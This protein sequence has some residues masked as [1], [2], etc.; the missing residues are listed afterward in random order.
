MVPAFSQNCTI[1][2]TP[3]KLFA[4]ASP[5]KITA[6]VTASAPNCPWFVGTQGTWVAAFPPGGQGN[7]T[8]TLQ[9]APNDT[10]GERT[11]SLKIGNQTI[12][13]TQKISAQLFDDVPPSSPFFDSIALMKTRAI[14]AGCQATGLQ[15]CPDLH[16]T[17]GQLAIFMTRVVNGND[18]FDAPAKPYYT[19][20]PADHV[21]FRWIQKAREFGLIG[22][23]N[24]DKFGS[25]DKVTRA[26]MAALLIQ[27]RTRKKMTP[28]P[29]KALF[30][31]V[32]KKHP[33]FIYVQ[34]AREAGIEGCGNNKF[35]PEDFVTRAEMAQ[36]IAK[37]LDAAPPK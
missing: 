10:N 13:V 12:T 14:T 21:Y 26:E 27:A 28:G 30:K 1:T 19:D 16:V 24:S 29:K 32:S 35:C 15:Y 34:K 33:A 9:I 22:L 31:D 3:E 25:D 20:I 4:E 18:K 7:G 37:A 17:R 5:T 8:L 23:R 6:K 11:T 2:V 36:F